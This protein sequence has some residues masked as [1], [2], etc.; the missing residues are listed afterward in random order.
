MIINW[1]RLPAFGECVKEKKASITPVDKCKHIKNTKPIIRMNEHTSYTCRVMCVCV[2]FSN[3]STNKI[4]D[5][6]AALLLEQHT[7][8]LSVAFLHSPN[9]YTSS[10]TTLCCFIEL[11]FSFTS[12]WANAFVVYLHRFVHLK[13][14]LTTDLIEGQHFAA[15][16][17]L[18]G[19]FLCTS[20]LLVDSQSTYYALHYAYLL[21]LY[22]I[23][24]FSYSIISSLCFT[25]TEALINKNSYFACRSFYRPK[26]NKQ[27]NTTNH[28][29]LLLLSLLL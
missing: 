29:P 9:T 15:K 11:Y 20:R 19:T 3:A 26:T 13:H 7:A 21:F 17:C 6:N 23:P 12:S 2:W 16:F 8:E 1:R 4:N 25:E 27:S 28:I 24:S 10:S 14:F 18:F 22:L 5:G